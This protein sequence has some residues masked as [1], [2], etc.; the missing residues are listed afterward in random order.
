M[1]LSKRTYVGGTTKITAANL[2]DIQDSIIALED[3][4][5]TKEEVV[6]ALEY[7]PAKASDIPTT[8]ISANTAAR[9]SHS[10]KDVL[11]NITEIASISGGSV[12]GGVNALVTKEVL[13]ST[14]QLIMDE[15]PS[16]LKNPY[17]LT[18]TGASSGTYDGSSAVTIN[19]P[20]G[21]TGGT[22]VTVDSDLS[23][24]STNPVQNK[25]IKSA[26]DEKLSTSGGTLTGNLTGKY[27]AGTWLQTTEATELSTTPTKI[28]VLDSKGW[29][30]YRTLEHFKSDLGANCFINVKDYGATGNGTTDDTEAIQSALDASNTKGIPYV[31]FPSGTYKISA[32][33]TDNNFYT[34]LNLYSGQHLIFDQVTLQLTANSYDFYAIINIHN[35]SNVELSGNLTIIGDRESHTGTTGESGHGIR[36]VNSKNVYVHDINVQHTWGDGVCVGGNGTMDEISKNVTIERVQTYKCSRNG[37]SIIEAQDVVVRDCDFS[38]TDRTNPQYGIDIEPNLGTA[39][40]I[41]IENVRMLNNGVGSFT[42]YVKKA[43]MPGTIALR[44]I[45]TD[46]KT[47]IYTS[48]DSGATFDVSVIG[49]KHTQK[50]TVTSSNSPTLRLSGTGNLKVDQLTVVNNSSRTV[51]YPYNAKNIYITGIKVIDDPSVST[52]G[53]LSIQSSADV[54]I[55]SVIIDGFLSRNPHEVTW[56]SGNSIVVNNTQDTNVNLNSHLTTGGSNESYKL[57]LCDKTLVLG[58]ALSAKARVFIPY[59]YGNVNPFRVVNTTATEI[60]LYTTVS[61]GITFVGDVPGGS[62]A[63]SAALTGNASYEVTPMLVNGLVYVRKLNTR[64]PVKTSEITNDSGYQTAA[65]VESTVTGKGYQTVEQVESTVTAKGYQTAAQV[66]AAI[67]AAIGAAMEA[68][69]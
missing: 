32:T 58:T 4:G 21:D 23:S 46:S 1:A 27:I 33:S 52:A 15:I 62:S 9:H 49:W 63:N 37:L 38:Y 68:S 7:T 43:T 30:Y 14:S 66:G 42:L 67:T 22:A 16:E 18:F 19:I 5:I 41:L 26:L 53:T 13:D 28:P 44:N 31:R 11:D 35:I 2:N 60:Q 36:I 20:S 6:D 69:Y 3:K 29:I 24:T 48:S 45:E 25:V 12:T 61:A 56:H 55:D 59:T 64:V 34:A 39:T 51:I 47:N 40:N 57:L 54:S 8:D 50:S 65:Q 10:N 17:A